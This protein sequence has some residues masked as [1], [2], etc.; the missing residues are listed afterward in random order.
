MKLTRALL[1][2]FALSTSGCAVLSADGPPSQTARALVI[3]VSDAP[4]AALAE[5]QPA[6]PGPG[7][8]WVAGY[9][10]FVA[11]HHVWRPGRWV[12]AKPGFE[13]S[14]ARYEWTGNTW[15]FHVPHW[16]RRGISQPTQLA[17]TTTPSPA[18][19]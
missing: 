14:R 11:G 6:S 18:Y 2:A 8:I 10:D 4:P 7:H 12:Q 1:A 3:E 19:N 13:Y 16:K 5:S 15:V 9:Q 17:T